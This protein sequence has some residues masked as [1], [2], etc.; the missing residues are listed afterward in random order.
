MGTKDRSFADYVLR[1]VLSG[2]RGI[3]SRAMFGGWG[4]YKD[5]VFFALIADG[6]LYFK[7][8]DA[9]RADFEAAG[10]KPFRYAR[11]GRAAVTMSYWQVPEDVLERKD[12]IGRWVARS[13]EAAKRSSKK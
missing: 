5:G 9:N 6:E 2:V 4:I 8:D 3:R 13:V 1:D 7:A 11:K 12:E 10:S